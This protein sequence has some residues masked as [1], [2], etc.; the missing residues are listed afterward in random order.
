[1]FSIKLTKSKADIYY[2]SAL[3][4]GSITWFSISISKD[5]VFVYI[6]RDKSRSYWSGKKIGR[7]SKLSIKFND[8]KKM[9]TV[10]SANKIII[11]SMND[12]TK[13]KQKAIYYK[14]MNANDNSI[15]FA[16]K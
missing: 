14:L 13:I 15:E 12:Y 6:S 16:E 11:H 5:G 1:M 10:N 8:K 7:S 3:Q 9:I 2:K 4:T